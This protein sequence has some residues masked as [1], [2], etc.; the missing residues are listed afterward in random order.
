QIEGREHKPCPGVGHRD[1]PAGGI[2]GKRV[3]VA[4]WYRIIR[5]AMSITVSKARPRACAMR[6][7]PTTRSVARSQ[8]FGTS[9]ISAPRCDSERGFRI[10]SVHTD[11]QTNA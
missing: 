11:H 10:F 6:T 7:S 1:D 8:Q 5:D 3:S 4:A 9:T 2:D